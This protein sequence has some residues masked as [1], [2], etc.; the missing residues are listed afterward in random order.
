MNGKPVHEIANTPNSILLITKIIRNTMD[1]FLPVS[2]F[3]Y[4]D[5]YLFLNVSLYSRLNL[6]AV[7]MMIKNGNRMMTAIKKIETN[8]EIA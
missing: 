8:D 5:P 2:I 4:K 6:F 7:K 3:S 1:D